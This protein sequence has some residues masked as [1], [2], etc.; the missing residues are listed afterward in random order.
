MIV[1]DE[2][3]IALDLE[4]TLHAAG[5]E[6]CATAASEA[7]A[8]TQAQSLRPDFAVVDRARSPRDGRVVARV[9][10][11]RCGAMVLFATSQCPD[12]QTLARTGAAA[13][14]PKP[15]NASDLGAAV[16]AI[17]LIVQ[18]GRPERMPDP[19]VTLALGPDQR[20]RLTAK[21]ANA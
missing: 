17:G 3:L 11:E 14:L 13:C 4:Q 5:F 21:G 7:E 8:L 6:V 19:M 9:L 15:Y 10:V 12:I 18:G 16:E 20:S 1:E 2:F